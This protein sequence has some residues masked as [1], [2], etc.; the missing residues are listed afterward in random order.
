[1]GR[2]GMSKATIARDLWKQAES[3]GK[4]AV[5]DPVPTDDH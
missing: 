4:S 2:S 1:M 3:S 5:L